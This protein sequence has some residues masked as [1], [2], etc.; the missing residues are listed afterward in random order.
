MLRGITSGLSVAVLAL[1]LTPAD[2]NAQTEALNFEAIKELRND[3]GKLNKGVTAIQQ[4]ISKLVSHVNAHG[5]LAGG[6]VHHADDLSGQLEEV[7]AD[8][9]RAEQ[10]RRLAC[11]IKDLLKCADNCANC[12]GKDTKKSSYSTMSYY[13][14]VYYTPKYSKKWFYCD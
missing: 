6:H 11:A 2:A 5:T 7:L 10:K 8:Y 4:D 9:D 13:Q 14:P 12:D 3:V 1:G